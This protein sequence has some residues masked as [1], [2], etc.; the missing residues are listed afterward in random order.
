MQPPCG[1]AGRPADQP[2]DHHPNPPDYAESPGWIDWTAAEWAEIVDALSGDNPTLELSGL[3]PEP[4]TLLSAAMQ[5]SSRSPRLPWHSTPSRVSA[6]LRPLHIW[7]PCRAPPFP[8]P[9]SAL[10]LTHAPSRSQ[11]SQHRSPRP[12]SSASTSALSSGNVASSRP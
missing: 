7:C 9:L 4:G 3:E 1:S 5:P 10:P 8:I 2:D 11:P 6:P 12:R